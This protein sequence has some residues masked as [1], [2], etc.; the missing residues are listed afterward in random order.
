MIDEAVDETVEQ[1]GGLSPERIN[2]HTPK[3]TRWR[4]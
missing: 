1:Q 3:S 2:A 4:K